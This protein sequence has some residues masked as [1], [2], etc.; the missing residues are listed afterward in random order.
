MYIYTAYSLSIYSELPLPELIAVPCL[1]N[2]FADVTI[3]LGRLDNVT[4]SNGSDCFI[5]QVSHVGIFLICQGKEIVVDPVSGVDEAL[6]RTILLGPILAV[7]LRQRRYLVLH[8]SSIAI[9]GMAVAF[10]AESGWGKS[11]LAEAFHTQGYAVLTDDLLAIKVDSSP[12]LVLP[13][14]PQIK[15]WPDAALS[16]GH[17]LETLPFLHVQTAKRSHR[18]Q[19]GFFQDSLPLK[20]IYVLANGT[21]HAV[22][23][24]TP[25]AGFI[26]LVRHTRAITLLKDL[27]FQQEHLHQC[28]NLLKHV[29]VRRLERFRSL[30]SLPDLVQLVQQDLETL[31]E[32]TETAPTSDVYPDSALL[33]VSNSQW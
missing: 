32:N 19:Q 25:Q 22:V 9:N 3:R 33:A 4:K 20:R 27:Q 31:K 10:M 17:T 30:S 11:T 14:F 26:E 13:S 7:L 1:S 8:A 16:M 28:T 6:L 23:P 21:Q 5:G 18:L 24:L 15:L 12:P 2:C 29:S